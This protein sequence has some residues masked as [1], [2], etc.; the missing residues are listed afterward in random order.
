[1]S[2][3]CEPNQLRCAYMLSTCMHMHAHAQVIIDFY[4]VVD[5]RDPKAV[6]LL[7]GFKDVLDV[8]LRHLHDIMLLTFYYCPSFK[9]PH[10]GV[11]HTCF[12]S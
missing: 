1:M 8:G 7:S 11:P 5:N 4:N 12:Y 9:M 10:A 6:K 2:H 3:P